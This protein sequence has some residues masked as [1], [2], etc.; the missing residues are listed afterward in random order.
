MSIKVT[1][2]VDLLYN[3]F[4]VAVCCSHQTCEQHKCH[5]ANCCTTNRS[6]G[7]WA[8]VVFIIVGTCASAAR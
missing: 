2:V 1:E 8:L 7:V 6:D 4:S 3:K 5:N